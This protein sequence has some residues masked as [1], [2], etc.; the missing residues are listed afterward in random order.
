MVAKEIVKQFVLFG[1]LKD[2]EWEEL[3][4]IMQEKLYPEGALVFSE[5]DSSTELYLVLEGEVQIQ[6]QVAPQLAEPTVYV[7]RAFDIFGEF[8][9]VDPKPRAAS[10]RCNR[11]SKLGIIKKSDFDEL[12]DKFPAIGMN[13]YHTLAQMLSERLRRMNKFLRETLIR[14]IGLDF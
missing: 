6:I 12:V 1:N 14:S 10:A 11:D 3:S 4:K 9:F 13:F 2:F 8:A 7:V 5:G